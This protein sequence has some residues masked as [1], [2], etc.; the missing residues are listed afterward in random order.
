MTVAKTV[1]PGVAVILLAT[2]LTGSFSMYAS[3]QANS[4]HRLQSRED[5]IIEI[6]TTIKANQEFLMVKYHSDIDK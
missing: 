1:L 5:E 6:L 4:E 2:A 3:V